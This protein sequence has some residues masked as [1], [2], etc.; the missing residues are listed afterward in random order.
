MSKDKGQVLL[1]ILLLLVILAAI[2]PIMVLYVQ[3]EAKWTIKQGRNVTA[4]QLAEA[5]VDRGYQKVTESTTTWFNLQNGQQPAGFNFDTAYSDLGGGSYAIS[6]TSGPAAQTI[7]VIGVGRDKFKQETRALQ[8]VYAYTVLGNIGLMAANGVAMSG[9]NVEIEWGAIVSPKAITIGSKLHP[10]YWSAGSIDLDSNAAAPPNCDQPN[11]WWW[12]SYYSQI[13]A[14]PKIDFQ[15]YKSSAITSGSDSCGNPYYASGGY[16]KHSFNSCTN[17]AGRTYYVVGDWSDFDS[18]ITGNVIVL[19]NLTYSNG[20]Q[21]GVAGK[22][23]YP[24]EVPSNSWKQYCNDWAA[25]KAYDPSPPNPYPSACPGLNSTY[26]PTG[27]TKAINPGIHGFLYVGGNLTIPKGGGNSDLI[28]G[29]AIVQG[30]ANVDAN[31]H[32]HIYYDPSV[33]MDIRT[34]NI[35]LVQQS[36]Q[37]VLVP[38]PAGLP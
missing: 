32:A 36:W 13:P 35:V 4:F 27:L 33:S 9:A 1:G 2:V 34:T 7:T 3:N 15:T 8:V 16:D 10:S 37:D 21:P 30:T 20:S 29:L 12:H 38:W 26:A 23:T 28:H 6:I 31:S 19:G 22:G 24:A 25:Y 18:A 17:V 5:A 11:C 14:M